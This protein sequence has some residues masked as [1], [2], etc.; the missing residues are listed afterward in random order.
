MIRVI[1][2]TY[3]MKKCGDIRMKRKIITINYIL[4]IMFVF[5]LSKVNLNAS[6]NSCTDMDSVFIYDSDGFPAES[7][8][9]GGSVYTLVGNTSISGSRFPIDSS[10]I[11][12]TM[13]QVNGDIDPSNDFDSV[14]VN[15]YEDLILLR[16]S[17]NENSDQMSGVSFLLTTDIDF[18]D[19]N[20]DG[21][22]TTTDIDTAWTAM[23]KLGFRGV[24]DG[25]NH[26][27]DNLIVAD[28]SGDYEGMFGYVLY[29]EIKNLSLNVSF[30][31]TNSWRTGGLAGYISNSSID[32]VSV[33]VLSN[34]IGN[35]YSG[36]LA[37][38]IN[39]TDVSNADVY[40]NADIIAQTNGYVAG[41]VG[42]V[43]NGS[44]I[45]NSTV[46]FLNDSEVQGQTVTSDGLNVGGF[47]GYL[48]DSTISDSYTTGSNIKITGDGNVGGFVGS[49]EDFS[50]ID[51]SYINGN[52]IEITGN[53]LVGGFV[54]FIGNDVTIS[55][56][57]I[58][59]DNLNVSAD[60]I[61][62]GYVGQFWDAII[63][64]SYID[65]SQTL[66]IITDTDVGAGLGSVAGGFS[67]TTFEGIVMNSYLKFNDMILDGL[68]NSIGGF[69]GYQFNDA[70][71]V[72]FS[73]LSSI[74]IAGNTMTVNS[75]DEDTGLLIGTIYDTTSRYFEFDNILFSVETYSGVSDLIGNADSISSVEDI[76]YTN[77]YYTSD[78]DLILYDDNSVQTLIGLTTNDLLDILN[79]GYIDLQ[80]ENNTGD[81]FVLSETDIQSN[82]VNQ[83]P[84]LR[85]SGA[86]QSSTQSSIDIYWL[87]LIAPSTINPSTTTSIPLVETHHIELNIDGMTA[88]LG[89]EVVLP[90][91]V[92]YKLYG[93]YKT[94]LSDQ[95]EI[96]G[97]FDANQV[98]T[99]HVIYSMSVFNEKEQELQTTSETFTINIVDTIAPI[100]S[101]SDMSLSRG[102]TFESDASCVDNSN[103][104]TI[105][106]D[107]LNT[108]RIGTFD[109]VITATDPS[110]NVSETT[111][112][113]TITLPETEVIE[114]ELN[115]HNF[116]FMNTK[117]T[118]YTVEYIISNE[119]P[120]DDADWKSLTTSSIAVSEGEKVFV[121]FTD[122]DG[123][124]TMKSTVAKVVPAE[125]KSIDYSKPEVIISDADESNGFSCSW[126][127]ILIP[128]VLAGYVGYRRYKTTEEMKETK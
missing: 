108:N 25:G 90:E 65:I 73:E 79:P 1:I 99:Y 78:T 7:S 30:S 97:T 119:T 27:I 109:V 113:I 40:L 54:G 12:S 44:T 92:G 38:M 95:V 41:L 111:Q 57:F 2:F 21:D 10:V 104:C 19:T 116:V 32:N 58:D 82:S 103:V 24:F 81:V 89:S 105:E 124:V 51:D 125:T 112:V 86:I 75:T 42:E 15:N 55:N 120:K 77:V 18:A 69:T 36:G 8:G 59:S 88:E 114:I 122:S 98:G 37:G 45:S 62:G 52:S 101:V 33:S 107:A 50:T 67:G 22:L 118:L 115:D 63:N 100:I 29:G 80:D 64:E 71:I 6:T 117:D 74:L 56:T 68:G 66:H 126:W 49:V 23:S 85:N 34:I 94:D 93:Y 102:D 123:N 3:H 4:L 110:G 39:N 11:L 60:Y 70:T 31:G 91:Y 83:L 48:G 127:C 72:N 35:K 61:A 20:N 26:T 128:I 84:I 53:S 76:S 28:S 46:T 13:T 14:C 17:V 5:N 106:Y 16:D 87:G 43:K 9:A 47:V 121:R 96:T